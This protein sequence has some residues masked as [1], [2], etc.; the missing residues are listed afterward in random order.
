MNV[1]A[2]LFG[3]LVTFGLLVFFVNRVLWGPLTAAMDQRTR[4]IQDGLD[5]AE[6]GRRQAELAEA[7]ACKL[8][9]EAKAKASEIL[10]GAEARR[11]EIAEAARR[12]AVAERARILAAAEAEIGRQAHAARERLRGELAALVVDGA[13]RVL[14]AET[15]EAAHLRLLDLLAVEA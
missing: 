4:R 15:G 10:A 1:T 8:I 7:Q 11:A 3:Q 9:R 12:D 2:T 14:A 5:A 6:H 13:R